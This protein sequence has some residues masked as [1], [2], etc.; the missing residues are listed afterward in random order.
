MMNKKEKEIVMTCFRYYLGI[1]IKRLR[2]TTKISI[3]I[4]SVMALGRG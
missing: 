3:I 1:R 4:A 2:V